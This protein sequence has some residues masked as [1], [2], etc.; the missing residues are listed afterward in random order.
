[1]LATLTEAGHLGGTVVKDSF[2][3]SPAFGLRGDDLGELTIW[4]IIGVMAFAVFALGY[5]RSSPEGRRIG[6]VFLLG[7]VGLAAFGIVVDMIGVLVHDFGEG[8]V[9]RAVRYFFLIT[10]KPQPI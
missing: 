9:N 3:Y 7:I 2:G 10:H 6:H 5:R 1:M 8:L 4:A